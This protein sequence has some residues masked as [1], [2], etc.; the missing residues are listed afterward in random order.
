MNNTKHYLSK[1]VFGTARLQMRAPNANVLLQ[2]D[3]EGLILESELESAL[4]T[5]SKKHVLLNS[6]ILVNEE[7]QASYHIKQTMKPDIRLINHDEDINAIRKKALKKTFDIENGPLIRFYIVDDN[8]K[9]K[10]LICCHHAICDGLSLIYLIKDIV[11]I[12]IK[13]DYD[14]ED[15]CKKELTVIDNRVIPD[16]VKNGF[17]TKLIMKRIDKSVE[18]TDITI[19]DDM[20]NE[21]HR[22]FWLE[23][24]NEII[25]L[26]L[27]EEDTHKI[28]SESK[29]NG[30]TVNSTMVTLFIKAQQTLLKPKSYSNN[31]TISVNFRD[32]MAQ[33][34]EDTV[35]FYASAVRPQLDYSEKKSFW[36]NAKMI[37]KKIKSL[38][39]EKSVFE[40]QVIGLFNPKFID[41][42]VLAMFNQTDNDTALKMVRKK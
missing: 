27:L 21:I 36:E 33:T 12:I 13:D 14:I 11:N 37:N 29:K 4:L 8:H 10:L 25:T 24:K 31:I 35:G 28:I 22:E 2:V 38:I 19:T 39:N 1:E 17:I 40:S 3:F 34:P 9:S 5:A 20:M 7:K 26:D 42:L 30:V 23:H 41:A 6:C 18:K 15:N 32:Y 16:S